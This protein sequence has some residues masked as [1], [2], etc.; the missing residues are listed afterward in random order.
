[1]VVFLAAGCELPQGIVT[2]DYT[3]PQTQAEDAARLSAGM[4]VAPIT[5]ISARLTTY[6]EARPGGTAKPPDHPVWVVTLGGAFPDQ[7]CTP[8]SFTASPRPCRSPAARK[9]MVLDARNAQVLETA[10]L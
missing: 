3:V 5:V 7:S 9:V 1:V 6:G 4:S 8:I 2:D 10:S